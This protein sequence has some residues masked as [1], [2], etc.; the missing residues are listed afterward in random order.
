MIASIVFGLIV[1]W[2]L[3]LIAFIVECVYA[4]EVKEKR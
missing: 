3:T 1:C 4:P 2:V